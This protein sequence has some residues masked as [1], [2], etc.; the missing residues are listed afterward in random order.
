MQDEV[1]VLAFWVGGLVGS[2]G[3][4]FGR[5]SYEGYAGGNW[6]LSLVNSICLE[7]YMWIFSGVGIHVLSSLG[8]ENC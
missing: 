4:R 8:A 5:R 6:F 7:G 2:Q 1:S 3:G